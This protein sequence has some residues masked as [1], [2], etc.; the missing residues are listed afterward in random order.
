MSAYAAVRVTLLVLACLIPGSVFA[1]AAVS[2]PQYPNRAIRFILPFPPGGGTD[3]VARA[4][5]Q[6][7]AESLGVSIVIDNRPGAGTVLASELAA[8]APADGYTLYM[9]TNTAFAI[10]PNLHARLPYD[11]V[12]D[13]AAI[14]RIAILPNILVVHPALPVRSVKE[15]VELAKAHPGQLNFGSSGTGTP[16]HLAGAMFNEAAGVSIVHVPYKGSAAALTAVV[17]GEM[18]LMF[19][20]LTSTL[21]F[22]KSQRLRALAVTSAK[23]FSAV[24]AVP[25]I[26]ASGYPGFEA[27]TWNGLFVPAGTPPAIVNRLHA[28]FVK[29]I[30]APQFKA[31]LLEQGAEAAPTTPEEL[32]AFVKSELALYAGIVKK[33]G[34]RAE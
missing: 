22:V 6:K 26:A 21:P 12:K 16:A 10:N 19:G 32:A 24:P 17:S 9:G 31:W 18:H 7:V 2:S 11:A 13:F 1:Q 15:L 29:V 23:P 14:T 3:L 28:E 8:H 33:S 25:T 4:I 5:G 27:V 34:M 20:S 30:D